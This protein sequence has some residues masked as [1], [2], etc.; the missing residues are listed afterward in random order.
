MSYETRRSNVAFTRA[1]QSTQFL[2]LIYI[3]LRPILILYSHLRLGLVGFPVKMLK[4]LLPSSIQ[5]TCPAHLKVLDLITLTMLL[6]ITMRK[7]KKK[8]DKINNMGLL[9][10]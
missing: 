4:A 9:I 5:A 7:L 2:K 6:I 8:H 10:D 3:S 1:L